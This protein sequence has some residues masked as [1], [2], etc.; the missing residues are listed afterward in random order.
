[1][2][3]S[4]GQRCR[5]TDCIHDQKQYIV[6]VGENFSMGGNLAGTFSG[7]EIS[8]VIFQKCGSCIDR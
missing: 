8:Y 7:E 4:S 3:R 6:S 5:R 1:M 2:G